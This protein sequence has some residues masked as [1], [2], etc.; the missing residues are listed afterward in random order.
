MKMNQNF[1]TLVYVWKGSDI[2]FKLRLIYVGS[3][4][5]TKDRARAELRKRKEKGTFYATIQQPAQEYYKPVN[6]R[7]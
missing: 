4:R 6:I 2:L 1:E 7:V 3:L 5:E